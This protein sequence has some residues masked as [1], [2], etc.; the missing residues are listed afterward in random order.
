MGCGH[1]VWS[2]GVVMHLVVVC[3][4][5]LDGALVVPA[6]SGY[7]PLVIQSYLHAGKVLQFMIQLYLL[8]LAVLRFSGDTLVFACLLV[9]VGKVLWW[10]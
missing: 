7:D 1:G 6:S 2:W 3:K 4:V 8:P 9:A 5:L 10:W